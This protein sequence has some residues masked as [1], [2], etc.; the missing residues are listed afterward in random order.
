VRSLA[1]AGR[2]APYKNFPAL[3]IP[4]D[5]EIPTCSN[6][7]TEWIDRT[8][9]IAV[10]AALAL[11]AAKVQIKVGAEAIE[12]LSPTIN[13]RD[14]E[15]RLGLSVGYLSKIKHGRET[16]SP[17]LVALLALLAD[18][19]GRLREVERVWETGQL[20]PRLTSDNVTHVESQ[21]ESADSVAS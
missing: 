14:L 13:Q 11:E 9:A 15:I 4:A 16:P 21:V 1:I 10:D 8:T 7:G 18:R 19:P 2:L 3:P 20:P 17:P 12:A 5:V 6:C